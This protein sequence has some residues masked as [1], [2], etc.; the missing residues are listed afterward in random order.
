M[1]KAEVMAIGDELLIGQVLNTN[2][3]WLAQELNAIGITVVQMTTVPDQKL[4]IIDAVSAA[5]ERVDFIFITGGLGP[6]KDDITKHTLCEYFETELILDEKRLEQ[7][8]R[9]FEERGLSVNPLNIGQAMRPKNC[10][11]IENLKGTANGMWF[12]NKAKK[13]L[14][15][16]P[17]VPYEMKEMMIKSVIPKITTEYL[18]QPILH[19]TLRTFGTGESVIAEHIGDWEEALPPYFKLAYLPNVGQVR[20]RLTA[21]HPNLKQLTNEMTLQVTQLTKLIS[22]FLYTDKDEE[23]EATV[24]ALLLSK[25]ASVATAESCTGGYIAHKLTSI[26][27]SSAYFKGS[28][29]A[30]SNQIKEQVLQVPKEVIKSKGAVSEETVKAMAQN[31]KKLYQTDYAISTSGVAGPDGGSQEKPVGTIWIAVAGPNGVLS[32]RILMGKDRSRNIHLGSLHGL[33]LLRKMLL[34]EPF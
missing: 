23:L 28:V 10:H 24:G 12:E 34:N 26:P 16:M 3:Q 1:L 18:G 31:V 25:Q 13:V 9:F 7:L 20:L 30:Y 15:S 21:S 17:G 27:G 33:N 32:K 4:A 11:N 29:V 14:I 6:T 19:H 22:N 2:A 5:F 8:K